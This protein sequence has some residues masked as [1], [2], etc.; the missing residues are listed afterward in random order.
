MKFFSFNVK[1]SESILLLLQQQTVAVEMSFIQSCQALD[2]STVVSFVT[3]F[4]YLSNHANLERT[5]HTNEDEV[6]RKKAFIFYAHV[7]ACSL[8]YT[9]E[10]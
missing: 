8:S 9:D 4:K 7:H 2:L 3:F 5:K 10:E 1:N 6:L